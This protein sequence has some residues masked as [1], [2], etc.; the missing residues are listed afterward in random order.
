MW[1]E[2]ALDHTQKPQDEDQEQDSAKTDIHLIPPVSCCF[3]NGRAALA[4]PVVTQPY[5]I[6]G[7]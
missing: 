3:Q 4:V 5:I 6:A 2:D 1:S 7:V